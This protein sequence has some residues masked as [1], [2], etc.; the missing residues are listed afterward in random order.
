MLEKDLISTNNYKEVRQIKR[1]EGDIDEIEFENFFDLKDEQLKVLN[2]YDLDEALK[3]ID[4]LTYDDI[5][6]DLRYFQVKDLEL[7]NYEENNIFTLDNIKFVTSS[8]TNNGEKEYYLLNDLSEYLIS[9]DD[10]K[11]RNEKKDN[12]RPDKKIVLEIQTQ[13]KSKKSIIIKCLIDA[14]KLS[15]NIIDNFITQSPF[16]KA[17]KIK[18][19]FEKNINDNLKRYNFKLIIKIQFNSLNK[20]YNNRKKGEY[21]FDL[22]SPPIFKTNFFIAD[23]IEINDENEKNDK[24]EE[25]KNNMRDENS[26]FYFRNFMDEISNLKYRHFIV[27]IQKNINEEETDINDEFDT[28]EELAHSLENLYKNGRGETEK[29]KYVKKHIDLKHE[30][31][32]SRNLSDF[33]NYKN[34]QIIKQRLEKLNFLKNNEE[35]YNDEEVIK[36][37][38]QTLALVSEN[39]LSYFNAIKFLEELLLSQDEYK[40]EIFGKCNKD[41]FPTLFNLCL[42]KILDK[43]QSSL[44]EKTLVELDEEMKIIFDSIYAQYESEGLKEVLKPSEND[45]LMRVQRCVI[46]PTYILF[47]PYVLEEGNRIIRQFIKTNDNSYINYAILCT[48][49]MDSLEEARWNNTFLI[50]YIKFILSKG[51]YIGE[52]KFSFFNYSQSQ[53][54]NMSCWLLTNPKE[55]LSQIGDFSKIMQLS[56]YAARISQ[57]LT[58]T[59]ETIQIQ[60]SNIKHICDK[61]SKDGKY[62]FSDG[63]GKISFDLAKGISEKLKLNYV[64]SCFQG[65]FLGCKGVWTTMWNEND[66]KIY[67][68]DSQIKFHVEPKDLNYFELCDY[69]RYIQ[70]Y[71]NRQIILLLSSL[72]IKDGN[73]LKKLDDYKSKLNNQKFVLSLVHY[74]EC[75]L[76]YF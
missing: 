21:F 63:V 5:K 40:K 50:E 1:R 52:K 12:K 59:I 55:I 68:R 8:K 61:K 17:G 4:S 35:K 9:D 25:K 67:C 24:N 47:T 58:T 53:F 13:E 70:S 49:K 72:G 45:I 57:T 31:Q 20:I 26:L 60:K 7:R 22:Q 19:I 10:L 44:E 62:T 69:S 2:P 28:N 74:P 73:F 29:Y 32:N 48:F 14:K 42:T 54:R 38:Y 6:D 23:D 15:K 66:S 39:I 37:F 71:L 11:K 34:N 43:Y 76:I 30:A 18:E 33:F 75:N 41:I 56:K 3:R 64:P 36:L 27:M 51:F 46:T 65:R 16:E